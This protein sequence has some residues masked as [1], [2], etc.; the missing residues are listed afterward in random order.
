MRASGMWEAGRVNFTMRR[1]GAA[2]KL[3]WGAFGMEPTARRGAMLA[4]AEIQRWTGRALLSRL[5]YR[6]SDIEA[7]ASA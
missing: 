4:A 3:M 2:R 7:D 1:F 6:D 5:R